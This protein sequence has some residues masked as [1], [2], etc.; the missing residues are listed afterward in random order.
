MKDELVFVKSNYINNDFKKVGEYINPDSDKF[1]RAIEHKIY[2]SLK[3]VESIRDNKKMLCSFLTIRVIGDNTL[4]T[5]AKD[6]NKKCVVLDIPVTR[7]MFKRNPNEL[8][9][10]EAVKDYFSPFLSLQSIRQTHLY[11]SGVVNHDVVFGIHYT[12]FIT[13]DIEK[14]LRKSD[15]PNG[16]YYRI[17]KL[18]SDSSLDCISQMCINNY[19]E[20]TQNGENN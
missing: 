20:V 9:F 1:D 7:G 17:S 8:A 12:L 4:M 10:V 18:Q 6:K 11:V 2:V 3:D 19:R 15:F 16:K 5:F 14:Q 13:P